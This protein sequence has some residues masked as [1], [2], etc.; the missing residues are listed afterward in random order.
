MRVVYARLWGAFIPAAVWGSLL[1]QCQTTPTP[2]GGLNRANS[3]HIGR[4]TN[5]LLARW[6]SGTQH[7]I[8]LSPAALN[9][10]GGIASAAVLEMHQAI[11]AAGAFQCACS[12]YQTHVLE[13]AQSP[14]RASTMHVPEGAVHLLPFFLLLVVIAVGYERADPV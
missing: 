1:L 5:L 7:Y 10:A 12:F 9:C 6:M 2:K 13:C 14:R 4:G 3:M 11:E 8:W